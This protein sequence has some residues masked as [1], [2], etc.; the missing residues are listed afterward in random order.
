ML[1]FHFISGENNHNVSLIEQTDSSTVAAELLI[2]GVT[3]RR[4]NSANEKLIQSRIR[5]LGE[6]NYAW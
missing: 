6:M 3:L 1:T 5:C 4:F 2:D